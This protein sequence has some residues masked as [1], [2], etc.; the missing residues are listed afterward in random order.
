LMYTETTPQI[1]QPSALL[2]LLLT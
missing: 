1:S 2:G